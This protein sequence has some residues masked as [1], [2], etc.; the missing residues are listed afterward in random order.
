MIYLDPNYE[1]FWDKSWSR[2]AAFFSP[3]G[4]G[5]PSAERERLLY[6]PDLESAD[7]VEDLESSDDDEAV[8]NYRISR[9]YPRDGAALV[10]TSRNHLA[11]VPRLTA[12]CFASSFAILVVAFVL[13]AT[14]KRKLHAEVDAGVI[15]AVATSLT[16]AVTGVA[17]LW[18]GHEDIGV[19]VWVAAGVGLCIVAAGSGGLLAW[20][21]A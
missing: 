12:T 19:A 10:Q 17:S 21:L 3:A 11:S 15:F 18:R 5:K 7:S 13:A 8:T 4:K 16:F 14:G 1:S 2:L 6:S 20:M 9:I